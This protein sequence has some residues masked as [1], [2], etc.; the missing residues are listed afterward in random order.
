MPTPTQL[1]SAGLREGTGF[2]VKPWSQ[3]WSVTTDS[4]AVAC[5]LAYQ[6]TVHV[7]MQRALEVS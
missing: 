3:S 5:G 6:Y 4:Q 7:W 2:G 1:V